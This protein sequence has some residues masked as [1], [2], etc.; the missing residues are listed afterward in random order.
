MDIINQYNEEY[1]KREAL[2]REK[3]A[4]EFLT[5][6][7]HDMSIHSSPKKVW[8]VKQP[9]SPAPAPAS[10]PALAS[11]SIIEVPFV[12]VPM[13]PKAKVE[14]LSVPVTPSTPSTPK[15]DSSVQD[16]ESDDEKEPV[17]L[18]RRLASR[19]KQISYGKNT[20]GYSNYLEIVPREKRKRADPATP[21]AHQNCSK[22]SFDGQIRKWRRALHQFDD[23]EQASSARRKLVF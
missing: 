3:Q 22:R 11:A 7:L 19:L 4:Q 8:R 21:D 1:E 20:L 23:L 2:E 14:P 9:K 12:D 13:S 10:A 17:D 6:C 18:E 15:P 16:E 5:R